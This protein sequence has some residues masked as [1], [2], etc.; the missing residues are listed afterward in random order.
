[1]QSPKLKMLTTFFFLTKHSG[2]LYLDPRPP[3]LRTF[4]SVGKIRFI[5]MELHL[6]LIL[7]K[8]EFEAARGGGPQSPELCPP[9]HRH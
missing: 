3:L 8:K 6:Y 7:F 2:K 4:L 5:Y 9:G 1:M